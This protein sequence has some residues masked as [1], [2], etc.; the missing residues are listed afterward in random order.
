MI[1]KVKYQG[2][3]QVVRVYQRGVF[4][5]AAGS[6]T[7]DQVPLNPPIAG[8]PATAQGAIADIQSN[9]VLEIGRTAT[10][11]QADLS[12]AGIFPYTHNLDTDRPKAIVFD[13]T[14]AVIYPDEIIP[15]GSNAIAI[16]LGTYTPIVG[17]WT[18]KI[19]R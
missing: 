6:T 18:L 14:G 16:H 19:E 15:Q 10:F 3:R 2:G 17:T 5:G 13:N 12:V 11:T 9:L 1:V 8:L 7:A 4:G